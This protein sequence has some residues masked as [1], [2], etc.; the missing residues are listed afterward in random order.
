MNQAGPFS[1]V[2]AIALSAAI[3]LYIFA[4]PAASITVP[5]Q[6]I[7]VADDDGARETHLSA[8]EVLGWVDYA[9]E[10]YGPAGVRFTFDPLTDFTTVRSTLINNMTGISDANWDA[11]RRAA[12]QAAACFPGKLVII[13]RWGPGPYATGGGFSWW[14]YDYVVVPGFYDTFHCSCQNWKVLAHEL[15]HHLGLPHTFGGAFNNEAEAAADFAARGNNPAVYDGD[16]FPDT[17][18]HP[19]WPSQE[20]PP[21]SDQLI[22]NGVTFTLP[23]QNIMSYYFEARSLSPQQTARATWMLNYYAGS[24][25][26]LPSNQK[27]S[28]PLEAEGLSVIQA[29]NAGYGVQ[30]M[31]GFGRDG[32]SGNKQ[33]FI[34][35]ANGGSLA[36]SFSVPNTGQYSVGFYG[37]LAPDFGAV[38]CSIDGVSLGTALDVYAPVV[39][40]TGGI[41]LGIRQLNAGNHVF[42]LQCVGK[43]SRSTGYSFGFDC[44]QVSEVA[45]SVAP[46]I[47]LAPLGQTV[48][49]GAN[50][51][52]AVQTSGS[53]PFSYQWFKDGDDLPGATAATYEIRGATVGDT[54]AYS[55]VVTN[56]AGATSAGPAILVVNA[57]PVIPARLEGERIPVEQ[58]QNILG[59]GPQQMSGFG[60][61]WSGNAQLFLNYQAGGALSLLLWVDHAGAYAL[62]LAATRAPD[63]GTFQCYLDGAIAGQSFDAY[64]STVRPTGPMRLGVYGLQAGAHR[65]RIQSTGKNTLSSNYLLGVDYVEL[66]PFDP[67][68]LEVLA[69]TGQVVVTWNSVPAQRYE[70]QFARD[71]TSTDWSVATNVV[72]AG[73]RVSVADPIPPGA[74]ER[75]YRVLVH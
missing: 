73:S 64:A 9:N 71:L 24:G 48:D 47:R 42:K 29:Q 72:A 1:S 49:T 50:V 61:G 56:A 36:V 34:G 38:Q 6:I 28:S 55:V 45:A 69:G 27:A 58:L 63:F 4:S 60:S 31:T 16:G 11:E 33:L 32:W 20:C 26:H 15:G 2:R 46:V 52:L 14:D 54:G 53:A 70:L 65:L 39:L 22:L 23:L 51:V 67:P 12:N 17:P 8:L 30:D 3:V 7:R 68:R 44:L 35:F 10:V 57:E 40:P 43:N 21:H 37:T 18:P 41:T 66:T 25:F 59:Y 74:S 19:S 75:Y 62:D 13:G 5:L